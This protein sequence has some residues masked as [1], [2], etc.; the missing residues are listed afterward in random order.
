MEGAHRLITL[1]KI[2]CVAAGGGTGACLRHFLVGAFEDFAGL[3][4]YGA[5][6]TVNVLGCFFIGFVFMLIESR[7]RYDGDSRLQ[8]LPYE[9]WWPEEDP[10][11]SVVDQF[12][13]D[14]GA[15]LIAAFTVTGLLGSMTTFSLFSLLSLQSIH[16][17]NPWS[18]AI[19]MVASVLLGFAAVVLG[20]GLA[21]KLTPSS[22][23]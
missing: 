6:M 2:L 7:Y 17:G 5:V 4:T 22:Q 8:Q 18:A 3:P 1:L 16:A 14:L 20:M 10:T 19:N 21:R 15:D 12:R 13:M 11:I 23:P 9:H